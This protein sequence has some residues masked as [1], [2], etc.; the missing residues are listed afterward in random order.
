M[1]R[2]SSTIFVYKTK[3]RIEKLGT[4]NSVRSVEDFGGSVSRLDK[5]KTEVKLRKKTTVGIEDARFPFCVGTMAD[6]V[7]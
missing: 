2:W 4:K 6:Q 3:R 5:K 7:S 1:S